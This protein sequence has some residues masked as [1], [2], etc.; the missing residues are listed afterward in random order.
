[1]TNGPEPETHHLPALIGHGFRRVALRCHGTRENPPLVCVHG[2]TRNARDFDAVARHLADRMFIVSVDLPGRG[3]SEWLAD[4]A[5]YGVETYVGV[6]AQVFAWVGRD[7]AFLGT[8]LGGICAMALA[9]M[10]GQPITRLVLNDIGPFVPEAAMR[11]IADYV[12]AT[13]P[14]FADVAALRLYMRRVHAPFGRLSEAE[15]HQMAA[16]S[17]RDLPDGTVALHYDPAIAEPFAKAPPAALVMWPWWEKLDVPVLVL[18]GANSDVLDEATAAQ[19]TGKASVM[20]VPGAGHA[21]ALLD[22]MTQDAIRRFL[23]G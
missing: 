23:L 10:P 19:M 6:L 15:W 2:L 12:T 18:R 4:P 7:V 8:S 11:R 5:L 20:T 17:R 22:R 13:P 16:D 14:R 9:A 1:M 3:E 21:P